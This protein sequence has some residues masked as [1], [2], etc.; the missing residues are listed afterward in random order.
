MQSAR[1]SFGLKNFGLIFRSPNVAPAA[2][3]G[4]FVGA[5]GGGRRFCS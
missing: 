3:F 5:A 2:N 4:E 1:R